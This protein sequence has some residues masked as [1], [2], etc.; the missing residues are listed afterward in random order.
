MW[1]LFVLNAFA[2]ASEQVSIAQCYFARQTSVQ[3]WGYFGVGSSSGPY[4]I[5]IGERQVLLRMWAPSWGTCVRATGLYGEGVI[6]EGLLISGNPLDRIQDTC[7]G[8][9]K[10]IQYVARGSR[11]LLRGEGF[12]ISGILPDQSQILTHYFSIPQ[13]EFGRL[14]A[15]AEHYCRN[16]NP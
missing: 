8:A 14:F 6:V 13:S 4:D 9:G 11:Q 10:E 15:Y 12:S 7:H 3:P 5:P 16:L 2:F 1:L